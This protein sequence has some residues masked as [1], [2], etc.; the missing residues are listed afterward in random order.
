[1]GFPK[2]I[3]EFQ[4]AF[5]DEEACCRARG[6]A[7][8]SVFGAASDRKRVRA[9]RGGLRTSRC[10]RTVR[11]GN[12]GVPGTGPDVGPRQGSHDGPRSLRR[13]R[14]FSQTRAGLQMF[15][16]TRKLGPSPHCRQRGDRGCRI[17]AGTPYARCAAGTSCSTAAP[18]P[19]TPQSPILTP[20]ASAAPVPMNA[21]MPSSTFPAR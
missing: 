9:S 18:A 20:D 17:V 7:E 10:A 19:T 5:P 16:L 4:A 12:L 14:P 8:A 3:Q 15:Q 2:T 13:H 6:R 21:P 11:A 1:M